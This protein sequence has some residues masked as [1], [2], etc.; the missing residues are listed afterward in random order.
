MAFKQNSHASYTL[1]LTSCS[2]KGSIIGGSSILGDRAGDED[3]LLSH[4]VWPGALLPIS[5]NERFSSLMLVWCL[6]ISAGDEVSYSSRS[7]IIQGDEA[8]A[9]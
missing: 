5:K 6:T 7:I 1:Q 2:S 3:S 4:S 9:A 8:G